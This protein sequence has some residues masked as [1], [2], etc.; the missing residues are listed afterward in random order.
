MKKE[1]I[2]QTFMSIFKDVSFE[3]I[4]RPI[5]KCKVS[6]KALTVTEKDLKK[7]LAK[8]KRDFN[9]AKKLFKINKI[10]SDELFDWEF[11]VSEI[12]EDIKRFIDEADDRDI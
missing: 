9:K 2:E 11:R 3:V 6:D 10:S 8:A 4:G 12:T 7:M 5:K 1:S